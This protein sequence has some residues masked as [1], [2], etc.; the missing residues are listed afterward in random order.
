[1][2]KTLGVVVLISAAF[3]ILSGRAAE[4]SLNGLQEPLSIE[5]GPVTGT[6]TIQWIAC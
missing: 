3:A 5:G 2:R 6:P 4:L 1:M